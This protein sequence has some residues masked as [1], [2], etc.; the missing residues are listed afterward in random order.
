[1]SPNIGA[2][3]LVFNFNKSGL[4]NLKREKIISTKAKMVFT[5]DSS[6]CFKN[7][8]PK[9]IPVIEN[10]TRGNMLRKFICLQSFTSIAIAMTQG[11]K[12]IS[13]VAILTPAVIAIRGMAIRASA[14]PKA[15]LIV[16]AKNII[17]STSNNSVE[18]INS[19]ICLK[20]NLKNKKKYLKRQPLFFKLL[21]LN[22]VF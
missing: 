22:K 6:V 2:V 3:L 20:N 15:A 11:I 18:I 16:D 19:H 9:G 14:K 7:R 5:I 4:I 8:I 17:S 12:P 10:N 13:G 21:R 1:M